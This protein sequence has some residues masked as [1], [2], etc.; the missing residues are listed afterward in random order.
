[1]ASPRVL[2]PLIRPFAPRCPVTLIDLHLRLAIAD[3]LSRTK[4]YRITVE[5]VMTA[6]DPVFRPTLPAGVVIDVIEAAWMDSELLEPAPFSMFTPDELDKE[7]TAARWLTQS[8]ERDVRVVPGAAG[9][10]VVNLICSLT[11]DPSIGCDYEI[12]DVL[13]DRH[14]E[15]LACGALQRL[16]AIP[17][18]WFNAAVADER[19]ARFEA[20][21]ARHSS[22][23]HRGQQRAP[24]RVRSRFY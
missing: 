10:L 16:L 20:A 3:F 4:L 22:A 7:S 13:L 17:G 8:G 12:P 6:D 11:T 23:N 9:T 5:M 19:G 24:R 15:A 1:M 18:D 2:H 21:I 14:S